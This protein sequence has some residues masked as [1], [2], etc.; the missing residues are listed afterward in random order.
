[1]EIELTDEEMKGGYY[2]IVRAACNKLS[3]EGIQNYIHREYQNIAVVQFFDP[4]IF[5]KILIDY[6]N[7]RVVLTPMV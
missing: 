1:M 5:N 7:K 2:D 3:A 4:V 6:P